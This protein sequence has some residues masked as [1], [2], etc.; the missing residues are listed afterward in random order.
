M[1]K[2]VYSL[3]II[4]VSGLAIQGFACSSKEMLDA[5]TAYERKEYDK[6]IDNLQRELAKNPNNEEARLY[7]VRIRMEQ[8][9]LREAAKII[10]DTTKTM[11]NP[12]FKDQLPKYKN[13]LWVESYNK[14]ITSYNQY[15]STNDEAQLDSA[16]YY[17]EIGSILRPTLLDFYFLRGNVLQL[18]GD[19]AASLKEYDKYVNGMKE[20]IAFAYNNKF[21]INQNI[22]EVKSTLSLET[23]VRLDTLNENNIQRTD[24][25]GEKYFY[26]RWNSST[27]EYELKGWRTSFPAD[28]L[29]NE[30]LTFIEFRTDVFFIL[31]EYYYDKKQYDSALIYLEQYQKIDPMNN[32]SNSSIIQIY[33]DMGKEDVA[34]QKLDNLT[35]ENPTNPLYWT[36]WADMLANLERFDDAIS[37]YEEALKLDPNYDFALRNIASTY[38][39]KA[40][41]IQEEEKD[42]KEKDEKYE[43]NVDRY[44]PLIEK[45]IEYFEKARQTDTFK[46]DFMLL[47]ELANNYIVLNKLKDEKFKQVLNDI[48]KVEFK[49]EESQKELFYTKWLKIASDIKDNTRIQYISKKI[50]Q[51]GN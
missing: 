29:D 4:I 34:L 14:G 21:Q 38:K 42:L 31:S 1:K 48:Q 11:T 17:F 30:K 6:A 36:M 20:Q 8:G 27:N 44:F 3:I 9:D 28:W 16:S 37:K 18:K 35:K 2:I 25:S 51:L 5:K 33:K 15:F 46:N 26:S 47:M 19:T 22:E 50:G 40:V 13:K 41:K 49:V 24:V 32:N 43:I 39:N 23:K 10:M 12:K 7:L 45:S